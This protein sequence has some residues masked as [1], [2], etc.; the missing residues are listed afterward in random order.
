MRRTP[1]FRINNMLDRSRLALG[2]WQ[3]DPGEALAVGV[4]P[5][6]DDATGEPLGVVRFAL[7]KKSWWRFWSSPAG[8][9]ISE[10]DDRALMMTVRPSRV[11]KGVWLVRDCDGN[12]V[13]KLR[14]SEVLDPWSRPFAARTLDAAGA[15][16]LRELDG[17]A[18]A[19][20]TPTPSGDDIVTF[21]DVELTNPFL[22]MLVLGSFLLLRPRPT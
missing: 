7:E 10:T 22:R 8:L 4:R 16:T 14:G 6:R 20:C 3:T 15:W 9:E 19:N 5:V 18:Y 17:R 12:D 2:P 21:L 11:A 13:G 1:N